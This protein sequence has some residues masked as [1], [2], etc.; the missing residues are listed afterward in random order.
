MQVFSKEAIEAWDKE[1]RANFFH[2]AIGVKPAILIG[3][4]N[5]EGVS[6]AAIF[7]SVFHLGSTPPIFGFMVRP[8]ESVGNTYHNIQQTGSYTFSLIPAALIEKAHQTA[9]RY[10]PE[11][12]EFLETQLEEFD[13]E[14]FPALATAPVVMKLNYLETLPI[15][16]NQ[17]KIVLGEV[18]A[19]QINPEVVQADGMVDHQTAA[20]AAVTGLDTYYKVEKLAR[21]AYAKPQLPPRKIPF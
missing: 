6:N 17:T 16:H 14:G 7:S 3:T 13:F 9:A 15:T 19:V 18:V 4:K 1:F 20:I 2:A 8:G 5:L 21:M 11:Q 12:N 10:T